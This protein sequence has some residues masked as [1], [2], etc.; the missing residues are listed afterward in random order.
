MLFQIDLLDSSDILVS[1][2]HCTVVC[3]QIDTEFCKAGEVG[4]CS[5]NMVSRLCTANMFEN[6]L[7]SYS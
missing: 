2:V 4:S 3:C 7:V 6:F 1:L 5:V